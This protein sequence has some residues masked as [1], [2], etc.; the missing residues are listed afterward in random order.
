MSKQ[1]I[2]TQLVWLRPQI[3]AHLIRISQ[4]LPEGYKLTLVARNVNHPNAEII[5]TE[6]SM[7]EVSEVLKSHAKGSNRE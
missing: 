4:L 2:P 6:D 3:E 7:T 1:A 5:L